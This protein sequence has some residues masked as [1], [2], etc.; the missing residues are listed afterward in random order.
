[1]ERIVLEVD[2]AI[3]RAWRNITPLKRATYEKKIGDILRSLKEVEFDRLLNEA[4][5][6]AADNGLTEDKLNALLDEED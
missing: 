4:G 3:A 5:K 1:M 2:N 6:I